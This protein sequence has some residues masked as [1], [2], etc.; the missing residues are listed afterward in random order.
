M[1]SFVSLPLPPTLDPRQSDPKVLGPHRL[2][3]ASP[4]LP[5]NGGF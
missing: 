4:G 1:G 5:S 3:G 2:S